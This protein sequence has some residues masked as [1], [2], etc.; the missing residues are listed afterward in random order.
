MTPGFCLEPRVEPS[1]G[2]RSGPLGWA[3]TAAPTAPPAALPEGASP[4]LAETCAA[5]ARPAQASHQP[6]APCASTRASGALCR[7]FA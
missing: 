6:P 1:Q 7:G 2:T 5:G 4:G 3:P